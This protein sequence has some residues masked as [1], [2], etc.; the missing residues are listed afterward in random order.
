MI[1]MAIATVVR[2]LVMNSAKPSEPLHPL[3]FR[4]SRVNAT[5]DVK[6]SP[7]IGRA[8]QIQAELDGEDGVF[9]LFIV[10]DATFPN[11]RNVDDE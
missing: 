7:G 6:S 4:P 1:W 5:V 11:P 3:I 9:L 2:S 8:W 10:R